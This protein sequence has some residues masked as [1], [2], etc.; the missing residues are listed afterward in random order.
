[1][2]KRLSLSGLDQ[3]DVA[4]LHFKAYPS[5][6]ELDLPLTAAGFTLPYFEPSG[7]RN[8]FERFRL[9]E[10]PTASNGFASA[11]LKPPKYLQAAKS[12]PG[13]Y[14]P[15]Y[16]TWQ[17]I[18]SDPTKGIL[19][20]EGELK[21]AAACKR[22][23]DTVGLGGVWCWKSKAH[24]FLPLLA[25]FVWKGR[26]VYIVFDSDA[27]GNPQVIKAENALARELLKRGAMPFI[28]RLKGGK[29]KVGLD[30]HLMTHTDEDLNE[31]MAGAPPW[32]PGAMLHELNEEVLYVRDPGLILRLSTM[33]RMSPEAFKGHQYSNRTFTVT[34]PTPKGERQ[35]EKSLPHEWLKWPT[36]AE[37]EKSVYAPGEERYT[38]DC[39]NVWPG[40]GC[41]PVKGDI[42]PWKK[43]LDYLF[44]GFPL[45]KRYFEQWLAY[46]L[47]HPGVKMFVAVVLW[48]TR[49]G[50][51][52]SLVGNTMKGI[53]GKNFYELDKATLADM[54]QTFWAE[55][56]QFILGDEVS[57]DDK[58]GMSTYLKNLITRETVAVKIKYVP[59][60]T[61][62][63]C[64]NWYLTS[65]KP[66]AFFMDDDDRRIF[67]HEVNQAPLE[68]A[69][70][71]DFIHW[72]D[73]RGGTAALFHHLLSLKLD[74]FDPHA[75]ALDTKAKNE[76]RKLSK[77]G[78]GQWIAELKDTPDNVLRLDDMVLDWT[79]AT[80]A[81]LLNLYDP[82][83]RTG[84][85]LNTF[86]RELTSANFKKVNKGGQVRIG[87]GRR[88]ELWEIRPTGAAKNAQ[89][90]WFSTRYE[91][92]HNLGKKY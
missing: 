8:C 37:V 79:L 6:H 42:T 39:I 77:S 3:T 28:I 80:T 85:T 92:E 35:E 66:D 53:Y 52:K 19:I 21:A 61:V 23:F 89:P 13:V 27:I 56:R 82:H 5:D 1:M 51:G 57:A 33:Q 20:T 67:V 46:P 87:D 11:A 48:G 62:T 7:K 26:T 41:E 75:H 22:G 58:R 2:M 83:Q 84:T 59:I 91:K 90:Q 49:Q 78:I 14:L 4:R 50:T 17:A 68:K 76:M 30:D 81:D 45:E 29:E 16:V 72:R 18:M 65:N 43:L 9:L 38:D 63:D 34:V 25:E 74:D 86:A 40:W 24:P 15:P 69:F 10:A 44:S 31:L 73:H 71:T 55:N 36:R 12:A 47:Q 60:Y 88:V 32:G 64:I 54:Q 70:Y